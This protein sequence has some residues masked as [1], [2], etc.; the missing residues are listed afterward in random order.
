MDVSQPATIV[1]FDRIDPQNEPKPLLFT[2]PHS[3]QEYPGDFVARTNVS[4]QSLRSAEDAYVD[5]LFQGVVT[6]GATLLSARIARA[7]IDLNREPQELD[8][9]LILGRLP[10]FANARSP[11]VSAG[12]GVAPRL[13][14][15][16]R[17]IYRHRLSLSEVEAR[18]RDYHT[19]FHLAIQDWMQAALARHRCAV[20]IDCHSMPAYFASAGSHDPGS[21]HAVDIVLGER[22]GQSADSRLVNYV[23]QVLSGCGYRVARNHPYAGGYITQTYGVPRLHRH[24]LQIEIRRSLYMNEKTL[25]PNSNFG[26]LQTDM[27]ALAGALAHSDLLARL[28]R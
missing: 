28:A 10:S 11:R 13:T 19:P 15:D 24:A 1:P 2:S 18:I 27:G 8:P 17:S 16:G 21:V 5:Q 26:T 9:D 4:L 7:F 25:E 12:L 20:L 3:G 6:H 23:E 14:G 22:F